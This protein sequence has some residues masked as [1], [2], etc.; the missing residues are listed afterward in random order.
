MRKN[1]LVSAELLRRQEEFKKRQKQKE[2]AWD[3]EKEY[4]VYYSYPSLV[5]YYGT[6]GP[7]FLL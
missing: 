4:G 6:I 7:F 3:S 1:I 5:A 2:A